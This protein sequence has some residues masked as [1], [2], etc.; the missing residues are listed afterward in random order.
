M[1]TLIARRVGNP[2]G[3]ATPGCSS[4]M[5]AV[6]FKFTFYGTPVHVLRSWL[7]Y[8][9]ILGG[10][11]CWLVWWFGNPML[12]ILLCFGTVLFLEASVFVHEVSHVIAMKRVG[13]EV[14]RIVLTGLA[15]QAVPADPYITLFGTPAHIFK[16]AAAGPFSNLV[17]ALITGALYAGAAYAH[18]RRF[19]WYLQDWMPYE[20][21]NMSWGAGGV[22]FLYL[23]AALNLS[24]TIVNYV[25]MFPLDGGLMFYAC[26]TARKKSIRAGIITTMYVSGFVFLLMVIAGI[27]AIAVGGYNIPAVIIV[28]IQMLIRVGPFLRLT[29]ASMQVPDAYDSRENYQR[30]VS[31][32]TQWNPADAAPLRVPAGNPVPTPAATP[33]PAATPAANSSSYLLSP[34]PNGRPIVYG[35]PL[36]QPVPVPVAHAVRSPSDYT[37]VGVTDMPQYAPNSGAVA[38]PYPQQAAASHYLVPVTV[39]P[40]V[41]IPVGQGPPP[42]YALYAPPPAYTPP[43]APTYAQLPAQT[44]QAR[45]PAATAP[46][47]DATASG[48]GIRPAGPTHVSAGVGISFSNGRPRVNIGAGISRSFNW[49]K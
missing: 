7:I 26:I 12:V 14:D 17:I 47:Q 46:P 43:A 33:Q 11:F 5:G 31:A 21:E 34:S 49:F 27:I 44:Q 19:T 41:A 9:G 20:D 35:P 29:K 16:V 8:G 38:R 18:D 42:G 15:G 10:L 4:V 40:M 28:L 1:Q 24:A 3:A 6:I 13:W 25:P 32:Y 39:Q 2:G 22:I 23:A 45:L 48:S 37:Y 36:P 30:F